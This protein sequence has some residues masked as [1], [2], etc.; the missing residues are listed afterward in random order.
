MKCGTALG[1]FFVLVSCGEGDAPEVEPQAPYAV[2]DRS[3]LGPRCSSD[4]ECWPTHR[5]CGNFSGIAKIERPQPPVEADEMEAFCVDVNPCQL[6]TCSHGRT[7]MV[8][9]TELGNMFCAL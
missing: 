6:V 5:E 7:C 9:T 2:L 3:Q 4:E 1:F 8:E